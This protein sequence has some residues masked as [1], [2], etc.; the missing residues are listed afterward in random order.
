MLT[1]DE[2]PHSQPTRHA[3]HLVESHLTMNIRDEVSYAFDRCR[4]PTPTATTS[5]MK[6]C[7]SKRAGFT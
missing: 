7:V 5:P 2:L 1:L 4:L 6:S 3:L